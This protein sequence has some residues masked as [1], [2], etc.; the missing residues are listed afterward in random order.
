MGVFVK[1]P[2]PHV[3]EVLAR[4]G[5]DFLILDAEH[6][7]FGS[8]DLDACLAAA[9]PAPVACLVRVADCS[10]V[11]IQTVLDMGADGVIVPHVKRAADVKAALAHSLYVDGNRGL[12]TATR[13]GS[14]GKSDL[15]QHVAEAD[16]R[17][18][19]IAQ[20]ED[21]EAVDNIEAIVAETRLDACFIGR[22][23]LMLSL[24]EP[25]PASPAVNSA[26]VQIV[27]AANAAGR[28]I[29][30]YLADI[31]EVPSCVADGISFIAIGSDVSHLQR[32]IAVNL[33]RF[34]RDG[35]M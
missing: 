14:Y 20:I 35:E 7:A 17:V 32:A 13:A 8:G 9:F 16:E 22:A 18:V 19:I 5:L 34:N 24:H 6:A 15:H 23:D 28:T 31:S 12:S 3:V 27:A 2:H 1:I 26:V 33:T 10:A 4:S 29:G 25:S 11:Q 30:T 21:R